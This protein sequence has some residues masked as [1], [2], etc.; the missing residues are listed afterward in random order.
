MRVPVV[1]VTQVTFCCFSFVC[2][3]F[4]LLLPLLLL[5][6]TFRLLSKHVNKQKLDPNYCHVI[7]YL[8][9]TSSSL[10]LSVC[11]SFLRMKVLHWTTQYVTEPCVVIRHKADSVR[12]LLHAAIFDLHTRIANVYKLEGNALRGID[13]S[14]VH[15]IASWY[16]LNDW[17][18][19]TGEVEAVTV[20]L[21]HALPQTIRWDAKFVPPHNLSLFSNG[22][23]RSPP[24]PKKNSKSLVSTLR[25]FVLWFEVP[26]AVAVKSS[27]FRDI[28]PY[29][30][31]KSA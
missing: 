15:Q 8:V 18:V 27:I 22:L 2:V 5:Q 12:I 20:M 28:T 6:L 30:P 26:A 17:E 16:T 23:I 4:F 11:C 13:G 14:V 3:C 1:V 25:F 10:R 29:S 24:P 21:L 7:F 19:G 9:Q 31:S